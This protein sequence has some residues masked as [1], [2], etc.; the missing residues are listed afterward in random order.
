LSAAA[1]GRVAESEVEWPHAARLV[2]A[3]YRPSDCFE[4]IAPD[5]E[6]RDLQARL[7][8]FT[9]SGQH[10]LAS[11]DPAR[12]LFGP[13]A[14][15]IN[16]PFL[17][18]RPG[19]FSTARQGAFYAALELETGVAE[20]KYHLEAAYRHEGIQEPQDLEYR[21]LRVHLQGTFHDI[22]AKARAK[23]PW[24]AIYDP[25][26]YAASQALG[27]RLRGSG[28]RGILWLSLRLAGG[29]CCAV[30]DPGTLRACRHDTY[31]TFRW[32]GR[33]V[34]QVYERRILALKDS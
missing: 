23:A 6:T 1:P 15:W 21:A 10:D 34:T 31:L 4:R 30:F 9:A 26:S 33:S 12:I 27:D 8:D 19:R 28:S 29:A 18:P 24:A 5:L 3:R 32:D 16:A 2:P 11:I 17:A 20:V 13:G 7:A 14:G 22:R 25:V